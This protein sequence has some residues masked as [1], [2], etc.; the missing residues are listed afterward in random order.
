MIIICTFNFNQVL[1][2][3]QSATNV[4]ILIGNHS[5]SILL[6]SHILRP[7]LESE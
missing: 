6:V 2:P 7:Q 3:S 1:T 4:Y 5:G